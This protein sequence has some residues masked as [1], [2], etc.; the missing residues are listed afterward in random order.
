MGSLLKPV[1][2]QRLMA[3]MSMDRLKG[4]RKQKGSR[5]FFSVLQSLAIYTAGGD[6]GLDIYRSA[7][8][9]KENSIKAE[10]ANQTSAVCNKKTEGRRHVE[11]EAF[12]FVDGCGGRS[13]WCVWWS[14]HLVDGDSCD[15]SKGG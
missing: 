9:Y 14:V 15:R 4:K 8:Y 12:A 10:H 3:E 6:D 7:G 11:K 2:T 1:K 5:L 13:F